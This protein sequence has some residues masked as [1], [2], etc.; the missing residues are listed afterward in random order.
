MWVGFFI[1]VKDMFNVIVTSIVSFI[2]TNLD[3]ILV[4]MILFVSIGNGM[5]KRAIFI[6]QYIGIGCLVLVSILG[7]F[8]LSFLPR[9]YLGIL[10]FV[11]II[12]GLKVWVD[13]RRDNKNNKQDTQ[14]NALLR[15]TRFGVFSV[16]AITLAN[17]A[18]NI[19]IYIP[20]FSHYSPWEIMVTVVVFAVMIFIWCIIGE[21]LA[22]YPLIKEKIQKYKQIIIP[23]VFIALGIFVIVESG[24]IETFL[25]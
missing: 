24:I 18:D 20:I 3:D 11:P 22:N 19:G 8:G 10:G 25:F 15:T 17:G 6:G 2:S 23:V 1:G 9:Q 16:V 4:L 21:K 13:Y 14:E 7:A 5:E 12:L